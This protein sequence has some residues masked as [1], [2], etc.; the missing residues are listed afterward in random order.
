MYSLYKNCSPGWLKLF[1][2]ITES[3]WS[4]VQKKIDVKY[5]TEDL[6]KPFI[7]TPYEDVKVII[8]GK[9]CGKRNF[10]YTPDYALT[11][12][13]EFKKEYL[14]EASYLNNEQ[15]TEI[16]F[17][18]ISKQ[19]V[20]LVNQAL[21]PYEGSINPWLSILDKLLRPLFE[22]GWIIV[23]SCY[24][25]PTYKTYIKKLIEENENIIEL[26]IKF[27]KTDVTNNHVAVENSNL[28][29]KIN[30]YLQ[31]WCLPSIKW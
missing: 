11:T 20:L 23:V 28:L 25:T 4:N 7:S 15:V 19:G 29:F 6:F 24:T 13:Y 12:S 8:F 30:N 9:E 22:R 18:A 31:Q 27:N 17:E 21:T 16:D 14:F 10:V 3:E 5:L 1:E 26:K 2:G